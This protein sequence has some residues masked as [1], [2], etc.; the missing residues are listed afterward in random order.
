M[1]GTNIAQDNRLTSARYELS[2]LEKRIMYFIIKEVRNQ[3]VIQTDGQK[4]LFNDLIVKIKA[5]NLLDSSG[6]NTARDIKKALKQLRLRSFEYNNG[7]DENDPDH[8]WFEVGFINYGDWEKGNVEVQLSKKIL[9]FL[10][11]LTKSFTEYSLTV[12]I[13]LKSKWSQRMYEICSQ[14]KNSGGVNLP[15]KELRRMF[16]LEDKY[17]KYFGF[18][19][20]VIDVAHKELKEL[21]MAGQCDLYF[22]YSELKEGRSVDTLRLKIISTDSNKYVEASVED[23]LYFIRTEC[24]RIFETDTKPKNKN[25]IDN[26][27]QNLILEPPLLKHCYE[28]LNYTLK[29]KPKEDHQ[30]YLRAVFKKEYI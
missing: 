13:S 18:K 15:V 1:K 20:K 12:A 24:K 22:E 6:G 4:D 14:W 9:P 29:N 26:V 30:K 16:A 23:T 11:E 19:T 3:F 8:K 2:L 7:L 17:Q 21:Y 25:F 28:K 10:V 5:K 27:M